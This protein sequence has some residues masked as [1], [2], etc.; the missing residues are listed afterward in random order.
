MS[1]KQR[2]EGEGNKTAA[3]DYNKRTKEFID[4]G[5]VDESAKEAER[6]VKSPEGKEL[7]DAEKTGREHA[8]H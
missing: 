7:R 5:R 3:R 4:S 2:N 6:A 1:G 8:K